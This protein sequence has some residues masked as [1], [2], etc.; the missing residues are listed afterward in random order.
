[1]KQQTVL[2]SD[3][4]RDYLLSL[5]FTLQQK[6][7]VLICHNGIQA[8]QLLQSQSIDLMILDISLPEID[9]IRFSEA[10]SSHP[11]VLAT[12]YLQN[13]HP[14]AVPRHLDIRF[15]IHKPVSPDAIAEKADQIL[16]QE[17]SEAVQRRILAQHLS[18]LGLQPNHDGWN[19]LMAILPSFAKDP[20]QSFT[21]VLYPDAGR[22]SGH[23]AAA[24]DRAIRYALKRAWDQG[25][26]AVWQHYFP[27]A[28]R[29]PSN[30]QFIR[31][32]REE[33]F[34]SEE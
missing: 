18:A 4:G 21:K 16:F 33:F 32:M 28:V 26:P 25:D 1:M 34:R 23:S 12:S 2:I 31:R 19:H 5:I 15:L 9:K 27:G 11:P 20:H 22:L 10:G 14:S 17:A 7:R 3:I 8:A 13:I 30:S 29:C 6:Y 24:V